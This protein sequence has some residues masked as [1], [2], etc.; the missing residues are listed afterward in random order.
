[1]KK[2]CSQYFGQEDRLLKYVKGQLFELECEEFEVVFKLFFFLKK[3]VCLIKNFNE[4]V[5]NFNWLSLVEILMVLKLEKLIEFNGMIF[6][7]KLDF[8]FKW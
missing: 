4:V 5:N 8:L 3:D 6:I 1:M 7:S 2:R